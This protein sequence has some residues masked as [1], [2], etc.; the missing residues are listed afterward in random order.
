MTENK[1][2]E[3]FRGLEDQFIYK[4]YIGIKSRIAEMIDDDF[5]N[6]N[7]VQFALWYLDEE[8]HKL[9]ELKAHLIMTGALQDDAESEERE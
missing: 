5:F 6:V 2:T 3:R 9:D 8:R 7:R 1:K 4:N